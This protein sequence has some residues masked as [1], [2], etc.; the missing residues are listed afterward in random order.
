MRKKIHLRKKLTFKIGRFWNKWF[1]ILLMLII[2]IV[3]CFRFIDKKITPIILE[4]A[5]IEVQN[6]ASLVINKAISENIPDILNTDELFMISKDS[7]N[8][9]NMI[10]FNPLTVNSVLTKITGIIHNELN[11]LEKGNTEYIEASNSNFLTNTH[12]RSEGILF[13]I[14]SGVVFDNALLSNLGPKVPVKISF[15]GDIISNINTKVTN[16]GI[17]NALIEI[18]LHLEVTAKIILPVTT[19][20]AIVE[21]SI[22]L[23]LKLIQ[24]NIPNYYLNGFNDSSSILTVPVE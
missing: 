16:Y 24:G 4:Y 10:D 23:A 8:E 15:I 6:L 3:Y 5:S 17:N 13:E 7:N 12:K 19:E 18:N 22:P 20:N 14:P 21:L 1:F 11:N 2:T 9:I